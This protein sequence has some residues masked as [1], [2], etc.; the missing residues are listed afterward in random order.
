L[1][2]LAVDP[3]FGNL[4]DLPYDN[5]SHLRECLLEVQIKEVQT[6]IFNRVHSPQFQY[7]TVESGLYI[8]NSTGLI[9]FPLP[10]REE[11]RT[12]Y[13]RWWRSANAAVI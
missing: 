3:E 9:F 11:L 5:V 6:K 4:S 12:T 7:R 1:G 8:G 13:Y 10:P 2:E